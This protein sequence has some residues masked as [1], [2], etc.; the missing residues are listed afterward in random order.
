MSTENLLSPVY[1][2]NAAGMAEDILGP[3]LKD[4]TNPSM[5]SFGGGLP[6]P[7]GFPVK[8]L[9]EA[10]VWCLETMPQRALQ[11]SGPEGE[12]ELREQIVRYETGRGNSVSADQ[13]LVVSGSQQALDLVARV[14]CDAGSPIFV[15]RPTYIG[16]LEAFSLSRPK[17][18]ELPEDEDGVRPD[19]ITAEMASGIRFAYVQTSYC[20]PTGKTLSE[21]RRRALAEKA[22]ELDF[23]IVEDDPYGELWYRNKPPRSIW[24]MAPERTIRLCTF[25]KVLSPG[26]RLGY[27]MAPK[28]VISQFITM[29]SYAVLS[30]PCINQLA[31]ARVMEKG[32]FATHLPFIRSVY[33][34][35]SDIM[36]QA[37]EE[38]LPKHPGISWTHPEGGMFIWLTLPETVDTLAMLK[39]AMKRGLIYV[40]GFAFYANTPAK[41]CI[42]L[43]FVTVTRE[44]TMEGVEILAGLIREELGL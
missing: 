11:Y 20:N 28:H 12:P 18:I 40:P 41:N 22:R 35:H 19:L 2:A 33:R 31:A 23:W 1:S 26:M 3:I 9:Q 37:L 32:L 27:M 13:L 34:E 17:Y 15:Q 24:S 10:L 44:K 21:E 29:Q 39:K 42:R 4:G 14:L 38:K 25:S 16:A 8:E 30:T 43:S 6:C 5:I 36:L 7:E